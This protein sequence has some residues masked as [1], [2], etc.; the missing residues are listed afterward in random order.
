MPGTRI[1]SLHSGL[2]HG[3]DSPRAVALYHHAPL[4]SISETTR[5]FNSWVTLSDQP[6][7]K[8]GCLFAKQRFIV[9][10][11]YR[12]GVV[13]MKHPIGTLSESVV[14]YSSPW[15]SAWAV[16]E[17]PMPTRPARPKPRPVSPKLPLAAT[18]RRARCCSHSE[19]NAGIENAEMC[20][21]YPPNL[22]HPAGQGDGAPGS[23]G[24]LPMVSA[25]TNVDVGDAPEPA[26]KHL[27]M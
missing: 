19:G 5:I 26:S 25:S 16:K 21:E 12:K 2:V 3:G 14:S 9:G 24:S 15:A 7:H 23:G 10:P 18:T 8:S 27:T 1:R 17:H 20:R 13:F 11:L 4:D 22:S 6:L